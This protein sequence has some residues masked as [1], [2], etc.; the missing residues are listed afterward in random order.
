MAVGV[1]WGVQDGSREIHA[2]RQR[3]PRL[4]VSSTGFDLLRQ[5]RCAR[6]PAK[7]TR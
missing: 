4:T 7:K 3:F 1:S 6:F 2:K 5:G